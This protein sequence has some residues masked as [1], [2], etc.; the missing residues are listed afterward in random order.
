MLCV[1]AACS[2]DAT[3]PSTKPPA[4]LDAVADLSRTAAVGSTVSGGIVVKVT[5]ADGRP[6]QGATVAFTVTIGNGST[7][8]RVASTDATGQATAAWTLG[9]IVGGNEVTAAVSGVGTIIKFEAVGTAGPV[10]TIALTPTNPR[11]LPATDTA[12]ITAQSLDAFGNVT[13]PTPTLT[14]RDPSLISIDAGGLVRAL[15]RGAATYVV[16]TAGTKSDSALVTVLAV[17]QSICTGAGTA[18]ELSVGQVVTGVTGSGLCVHASSANAEYAVVPFFNAAPTATTSIEVRGQGI[19]P[20]PLTTADVFGSPLR[21]LGE[22]TLVPDDEFESRLRD[23]ERTEAPK[24]IESARS[25]M[26]A[27][28]D[29][30]ASGAQAV[31]TPAVGDLLKLNA[32]FLDFCDNA[33]IR[34]G[35][36]AAVTDKAIVVADTAN[37][38]GGFSDADYRSI[39]VTFDT[40]IDPVDRGA[41][42]AVTD[43]D[44]NGHVILFFTRAVN[45]ATPAGATSVVLGLFYQRDLFPKTASPGPC[46]GSNVGEMF[47][48]LVPDPNGVIN[49]N[50]RSTSQVL[51]FS[52][53]TVAHEYQHL[54]NASRRMYVNA[55]GSTPEE[56]WLDE[57]LAHTAEELNFFRA[58]GR[59]PRANLDASGF[60]DPR[61]VSAYSTYEANNFNRYK[62]YLARTELQA[63]IGSSFLD[64]DLPTRGAIWNFLR[65]AADHLP[66]GQEN[67]FW[68][69]LV[70]SKTTGTANLTAAL[71]APPAPLLRDWAISVF[72]D[73]NAANVDPRFQQPSWNL[74]SALTNGGTSLAFPLVTHTLSDNVLS[75]TTLAGNGVAFYR[76]SVAAGQD[77]LLD[78]TVGGQP[79]PSTVQLAVV[80]VR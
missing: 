50:R 63:P 44:S 48:L 15:R 23:R 8:P 70:N 29:V 38:P 59:S 3:G 73:D 45:E 58:S 61:F 30:I 62:A 75:T 43:I 27:H 67:T 22:P 21:R 68:F 49:S 57:G 54:I 77:A 17:G 41:F 33:D 14:V 1:F 13:S 40:L 18:L 4:H 36:V 55:A 32:N 42:G 20:L 52:N 16:A 47:Y 79:I 46:A 69:N 10:S 60:N 51:T 9:T 26:R 65:F 12:R 24:R 5:D 71:G 39:G 80:R 74:R 66:A 37:P 64:D 53:G 2:N 34:T 6:V 31:V 78:L 72:L 25:W 19:G 11:L 35:R 76:F 28:R 7:N 56:K